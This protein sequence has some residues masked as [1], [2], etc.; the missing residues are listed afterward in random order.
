MNSK[1]PHTTAHVEV[2]DPA[3]AFRKLEAFTR[4]ILGVPKKVVDNLLAKEKAKRKRKS[5]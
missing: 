3:A 1:K 4:G 5:R 2:A